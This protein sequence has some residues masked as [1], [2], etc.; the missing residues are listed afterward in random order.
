MNKNRITK[1]KIDKLFGYQDISID[2]ESRV[3]ILIGEN[4][5]G[6]TTVLN[7]L[8]FLLDK[9]F[10]KLNN[11]KFER[12]ELVFSNKRKI[13]FTHNSLSYFLDRPKRYQSGQF[14]QILSKQLDT[15]Y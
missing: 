6:K 1:F 12:I 8:Y 14:Y 4:G 3:K 7:M 10:E 15:R 9:K 13:A 2:F 11:I 5:L